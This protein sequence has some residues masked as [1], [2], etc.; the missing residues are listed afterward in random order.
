MDRIDLRLEVSPV[1][2]SDIF[3]LERGISSA[4]AREI[5][6]NARE[7]QRIRYKNEDFSFNSELPQGKISTYIK[8]SKSEEDL[9]RDFF[10]NSDV[11][12]RG[13]YR[14]MKLVR[15]IADVE[16]REEIRPSDIEEAIFYRNETVERGTFI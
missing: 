10:E 4:E 9:L 5:I 7:R 3:S 14:I 1:K 12:A 16:D 8:I 6:Q 13:Y 15:T 11:S 2:Y